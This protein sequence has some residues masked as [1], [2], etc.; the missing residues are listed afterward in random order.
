MPTSLIHLNLP[1]S[2]RR[3]GSTVSDIEKKKREKKQQKKKSHI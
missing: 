1:T 3:D 2:W